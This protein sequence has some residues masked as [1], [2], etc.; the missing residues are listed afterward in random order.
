[1][2]IG[3]PILSRLACKLGLAR[4]RADKDTLK[5]LAIRVNVSPERML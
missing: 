4:L 1:M 2:M 3:W 5:I